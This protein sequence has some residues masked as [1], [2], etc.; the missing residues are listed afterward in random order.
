MVHGGIEGYSRLP[1]YLHAAN[2]NKA[3]TVLKTFS[4]LFQITARHPEY[5]V[6]REEKTTMLVDLCYSILKGRGSIIAGIV[7]LVSF[8]GCYFGKF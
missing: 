8:V 6:T 5:G 4:G 3:A 7:K 2:N 1:V